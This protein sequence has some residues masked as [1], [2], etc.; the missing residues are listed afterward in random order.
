MTTQAALKRASTWLAFTWTP[1]WFLLVLFLP[2]TSLPLLARL[3]RSDVV[4][5]PSG[6]FLFWLVLTW[7]LPY[8]V[9]RGGLPR[10]IIPLLIFALAAVASVAVGQFLGAPPF[11]E[12]TSLGRG[13]S[14]LLTLAIGISFYAV[15]A[16]WVSTPA[17]LRLTL[18]AVNLGGLISLLWAMVQA[19]A[20]IYYDN[21]YPAWIIQF[22]DQ[23]SLAGMY[24][25]RVTGFAF[26]PSFLAH[27]LNMLYLPWWL[28]A[29]LT[30]TSAQRFR[31]LGL[32][33]ENL[34]L[35]LGCAGLYLTFSRVGWVAFFGMLA[36]ILLI[37]T[38][39]L[40]DWAQARLTRRLQVR[41]SLARLVR[42]GV[43]AGL[44]LGVG[45]VFAGA[46]FLLVYFGGRIESRMSRLFE[47]P[48]GMDSFRKLANFL[49]IS[50]RLTYWDAGVRIFEQFPFL[51]VGLGNAG[52]YFP[53]VLPNYSWELVEIRYIFY[54]LSFLPNI[55]S[56][57]LRLLA[58]TGIVGFSLFI[59]WIAV[60]V[61]SARAVLRSRQPLWQ[62]MGWL[63]VLV[64]LGYFVEGFSVDSFALPY[65]WISLGLMTAACQQS[66]L[67]LSKM[68][69]N[70]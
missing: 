16:A 42:L 55:K 57:W 53:Q 62:A 24:Q 36:F 18:Q 56:I 6:V 51:G 33:A 59:S 14:S 58:E 35:I 49:V 66:Q 34:L 17:R 20:F 46:M 43:S 38:L 4:A 39:R 44:L 25:S 3:L 29:T 67:S 23:V 9:R 11:K 21:R 13:F 37:G 32:S 10:Q 22:Q 8:L 50:A 41:A 26:E 60:Q 40:V 69:Q 15:T 27:Q 70:G 54:R 1:A 5:A 28:A 47:I 48:E 63:S 30:R 2:I 45:L 52:F 12:L 64:L 65:V 68:E 7:L 31:L 19:W 61:Q